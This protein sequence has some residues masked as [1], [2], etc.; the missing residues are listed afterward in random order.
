MRTSV[1]VSVSAG[2]IVN[3][4]V[5][6]CVVAAINNTRGCISIIVLISHTVTRSLALQSVTQLVRACVCVCVALGA[7]KCERVAAS[8]GWA[9]LAFPAIYSHFL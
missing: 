6:V 3:L 4:C 5:R 8:V 9:A 2:A 7:F 1:S